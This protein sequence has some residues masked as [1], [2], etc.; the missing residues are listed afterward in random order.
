MANIDYI[1]K[2]MKGKALLGF[3][4]EDACHWASNV[5]WIGLK[6]L[7]ASYASPQ[8]AY[9]E[10]IATLIE[11]DQLNY[12]HENSEFIYEQ[13]VWYYIDRIT[14]TAK[15]RLPQKIGRNALCPCDSQKKFKNCHGQG[16]A[17]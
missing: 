6:V 15:T 12:I 5:T 9:V 3:N 1:K 7:N 13:G 4:A 14:A 8:Q 10:F 2:T 17:W 16:I 11:R